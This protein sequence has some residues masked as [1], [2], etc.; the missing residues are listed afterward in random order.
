MVEVPKPLLKIVQRNR[1]IQEIVLN[2]DHE[3]ILG[4]TPQADIM[5]PHASVSRM[6]AK[7]YTRADG[8]FLEDL[9]SANGTYIDGQR[10]ESVVRLD[11]GQVIRLGQRTAHDP[12]ILVFEDPAARLL[13]E[14]GLAEIAAPEEPAPSPEAESPVPPPPEKEAAAPLEEAGS[15]L[16]EPEAAEPESTEEEPVVSHETPWRR[17]IRDPVVLGAGAAA[18]VAALILAVILIRVFKPTPTLWKSVQMEPA[19]IAPGGTLILHS[20]DIV[21]REGYQVFLRDRPVAEVTWEHQRLRLQVPDLGIPTAGR[22]NVNLQVKYRGLDVFRGVVKYVVTPRIEDIQPRKA[23]VGDPVRIVGRGFHS[24]AALVH[25]RFGNMD[26]QVLEAS[27]ERLTVRVPV[28]TRGSPVRARAAVEILDWVYET[29]FA[30]EV[31]PR[32]PRPLNLEFAA[33]WDEPRRMWEIYNVLGT[34]FYV[35]GPVSAEGEPP[36]EIA[37]VARAL[38]ETFSQAAADANAAFDLRRQGNRFVLRSSAGGKIR[39]IA[40]WTM[41]DLKSMANNDREDI[42]PAMLPYWW[43]GVLNRCLDVFARGNP[44]EA[45]P[46]APDYERILRRLVEANIEGGGQGPPEE[47]ELNLLKPSER[48]ILA[49]AALNP[50]RRYG[51]VSGDWTGTLANVFFPSLPDLRILIDLHLQQDGLRLRGKAEARYESERLRGSVPGASIS[52]ELIPGSPMQVRITVPFSHPIGKIRLR[53]E[54]MN[55]RI[56]GTVRRSSGARGEWSATWNS[57]PAPSSEK[58]STNPEPPAKV[59]KT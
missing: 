58:P 19:E 17:W 29:P 26:A 7:I 32:I 31:S 59:S 45:G 34:F 8:V 43:T 54:V 22:H 36:E 55:R 11:D 5:I 30:V 25:V 49:T 15:E 39:P 51:N 16:S 35:P 57:E 52:G 3:Y 33:R 40:S 24:D 20:P 10:I 28:L 48:Q 53:G 13:K 41:E 12:T 42:I 6:H 14:M 38:T 18:L 44:P 50:P 2:P 4:R 56:Q 37:A 23:H 27:P 21:P 47:Q 1:V 46:D 9:G